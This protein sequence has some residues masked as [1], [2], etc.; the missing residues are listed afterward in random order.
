VYVTARL[1]FGDG[2]P[3][4]A[5]EIRALERRGW[6]VIV[7]PVRA[8]GDIVHSEAAGL[9]VRATGLL[10][11]S[12]LAGAFA[13]AVSHP[14]RA[15]GAL[16]RLG[17][18]R[19]LG[20]LLKNLSVVPKALWLARQARALDAE[21]IHAHWA[22]TSAT[23]ALLA[24]RV[25]GIPWSLTAHRWDIAQNNLLGPKAREARFIRA[26]SEHGREELAGLVASP[27]WSPWLLHM[28]VELPGIAQRNESA[29]PL[30]VL[31]AAR[32]VEKKGH[33]HLLEA[34][35]LLEERGVDVRAAL[36]GGGPL[37]EVLAA[38]AAEA[39][40]QDRLEFLGT[41]SH[42]D[43]L[44]GLSSGRWDAAVLPS[45]VTAS[46]ELEGIPVSLVE[47]MAAGLPV[48]GTETGGIPE[49]LRDGAGILVPPGNPEALA[50]ALQELAGDVSLRARLGAA[51]RRRIEEEF[52]VDAVAGELD[53]RFRASQVADGSSSA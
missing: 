21:H 33:V 22:G 52:A 2:E 35:R 25:S 51:G 14:R 44:A 43:L 16:G 40:I 11:P 19:S 26:I 29:P 8:S 36:A 1:P 24:G 46:G 5:T 20:V 3:F 48:V 13:E 17:G 34:L 38:H 12:V 15:A 23:M 7:V 50:D 28:G 18:S 45:V 39:G 4:V 49:L 37:A 41:V 42:E 10:S 6:E 32:L 27:G 30:R 53:A 9:R 47:A 31:T